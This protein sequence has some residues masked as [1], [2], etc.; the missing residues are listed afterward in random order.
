M[1][2]TIWIPKWQKEL[3]SFKGIKSTF[4][5]EGNISDVYPSFQREG[6]MY[7]LSEFCSLNRIIANIFNSE[8]TSG[9][10]DFQYCDPI[11]FF[12]YTLNLHQATDLFRL[13]EE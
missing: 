4:I 1:D 11:F 12:F 6:E 7:N 2:A 3:M 10:Y 5:V 13:Y 9:F 8:E